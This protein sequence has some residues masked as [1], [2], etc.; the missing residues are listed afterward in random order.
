MLFY[1]SKIFN[2]NSIQNNVKSNVKI[3][4]LSCFLSWDEKFQSCVKRWLKTLLFSGKPH[5]N[6]DIFETFIQRNVIK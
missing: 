5:T 1:L 6:Q 2:S 3:K 4:M